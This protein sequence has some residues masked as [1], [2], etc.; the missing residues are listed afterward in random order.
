MTKHIPFPALSCALVL[1]STAL[2]SAQTAPDSLNGNYWLRVQAL[3]SWQ[4]EVDSDGDGMSNREEYFAGTDPLDAFSLLETDIAASADGSLLFSWDAQ[5]ST[6][7][8]FLG[9]GNLVD[10][11]ILGDPIAADGGREEIEL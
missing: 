9:S 5:P 10:W 11:E 1:L 2:A 4:W 8:H 7:F 6:R 3:D